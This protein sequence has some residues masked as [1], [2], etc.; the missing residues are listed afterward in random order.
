MKKSYR[1]KGRLSLT[2][3]CLFVMMIPARIYAA[4]SAS[5]AEGV[6]SHT[7]F[8]KLEYTA[9]QFSIEMPVHV[10]PCTMSVQPEYSVPQRSIEK[11]VNDIPDA[12]SVH[13]EYAAP[14]LPDIHLPEI[15][16]NIKIPDIHIEPEAEKEKLREALK[17]M[18]E[19]GIS[20]EKLL[21]RFRDFVGRNRKRGETK[22]TAENSARGGT[23]EIDRI[24]NKL[25]E[26]AEKQI[27]KAADQAKKKLGEAAQEQIDQAVDHA[28]ENITQEIDQK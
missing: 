15:P 6:V 14:R 16:E 5:A 9:P 2:V 4:P 23:G 18:D 13:P 12:P 11:P 7:R 22:D 28:R 24:R 25:E 3:L 17:T 20:P 8:M 27:D 10:V 1:L 26:E 19:L 21:Q